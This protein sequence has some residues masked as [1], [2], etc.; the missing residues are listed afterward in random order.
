MQLV[1]SIDVDVLITV[2]SDK[3]LAARGKGEV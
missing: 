2:T 1:Y 3:L